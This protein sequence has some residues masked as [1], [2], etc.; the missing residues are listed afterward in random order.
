MNGEVR[1]GWAETLPQAG[2]F[3]YRGY[4]EWGMFWGTVP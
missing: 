1:W 4:Q 2:S 3:V